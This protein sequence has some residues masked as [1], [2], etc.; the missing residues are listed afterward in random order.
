QSVPPGKVSTTVD[1]PAAGVRAVQASHSAANDY[2]A[3][4][5][6]MMQPRDSKRAR[7]LPNAT[8]LEALDSDLLL[9]CASYLDAD[10]LARL[11]RASAAFGTPQ[12]GQQRSLANEA[13]HQLFRQSATDEERRCLPKHDGE[14]DIGLYRALE[15]MREPLGFDTNDGKGLN[16]PIKFRVL[17]G[18]AVLVVLVAVRMVGTSSRVQT[19]EDK[20]AALEEEILNLNTKIQSWTPSLRRCKSSRL[21]ISCRGVALVL[22]N[23]LLA[24]ATLIPESVHIFVLSDDGWAL[25][26]SFA[27]LAMDAKSRFYKGRRNRSGTRVNSL[28]MAA[29]VTLGYCG[30]D[31]G[32][33]SSHLEVVPLAKMDHTGASAWILVDLWRH[34]EAGQRIC[35]LYTIEIDV[36]CFG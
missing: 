10:G 26:L 23:V 9:R 11:G 14:S 17:A 7:L 28:L 35:L 1:E 34:T 20:V 6:T 32:F 21:L 4:L 2:R 33:E 27:V 5:I 36:F 24:V 12:A 8:L 31:K 3:S 22:A 15:Q 30:L 13:A 29:P 25:D 19:L 18:I 16:L